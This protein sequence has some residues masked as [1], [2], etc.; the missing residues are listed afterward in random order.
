LLNTLHQLG[1]GDRSYATGIVCGGR[2][3]GGDVFDGARAVAAGA[4]QLLEPD[5]GAELDL[6]QHT[7]GQAQQVIIVTHRRQRGRTGEIVERAAALKGLVVVTQHRRS[8]TTGDMLRVL[9]GMLATEQDIKKR[10][11][12]F[13]H[14][15]IL[16]LPAESIFRI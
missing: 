13:I 5:K 4:A 7:V 1:V 15:D 14:V 11:Q 3:Q 6:D 10:A 8:G 16:N 12:L 9:T 2:Y